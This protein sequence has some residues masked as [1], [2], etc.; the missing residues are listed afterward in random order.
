ME[1]SGTNIPEKEEKLEGEKKKRSFEYF[2]IPSV[3]LL[4]GRCFRNKQMIMVSGR[5]S[6]S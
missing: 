1:V 3:T 5:P 4:L 2:H 6:N